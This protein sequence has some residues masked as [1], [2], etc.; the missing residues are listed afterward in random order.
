MLNLHADFQVIAE[1]VDGKEA[2]ESKGI[3]ARRDPDGH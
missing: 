3:S 1:A 2:V